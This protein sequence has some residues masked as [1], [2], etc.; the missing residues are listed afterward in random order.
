ME[1]IWKDIPGF[2]GYQISNLGRIKYF[3]WKKL[4]I[5]YGT[6]NEKGYYGFN[7]IKNKKKYFKG[8]HTLVLLAFVGEPKKGQ[9]C[10]HI[11][12]NPSDNCVQNLRWVSKRENMLNRN[13][14]GN[15]QLKGVSYINEKIKRKDGSYRDRKI[16]IRS[17]ITINKKTITLG[18]FKTEQEAHEAYKQAFKKYHGYE[19][20]G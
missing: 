3:K 11:N 9:E 1:E 12:R 5:T 19:W 16:R 7:L 18:D 8:V 10:D 17:Q 2:E 4:S 6:K 14:Y 13:N 15:C 20:M